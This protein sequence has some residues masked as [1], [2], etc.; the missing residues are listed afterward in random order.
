VVKIFEEALEVVLALLGQRGVYTVL[1]ALA[2]GPLRFGALQQLTNLPPRALSLRLKELE[3]AELLN[4]T[5]YNE[6][7][8]RVEYDLTEKGQALSPALNALAQ[9]ETKFS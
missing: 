6:V 1:R 9:W 2:S 3:E 5:E 4:R 7:P 8:P